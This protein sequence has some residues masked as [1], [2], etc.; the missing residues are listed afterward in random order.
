MSQIP[1]PLSH[2]QAAKF[3]GVGLSVIAR[4]SDSGELPCTNIGTGSRKHRI[5]KMEDL[6]A[7]KTRQFGAK[8]DAGTLLTIEQTAEALGI[9]KSGVQKRVQ[10]KQF[11]MHRQGRRWF[12]E[13]TSVER[14]KQERERRGAKQEINGQQMIDFLKEEPV[15]NSNG[16]EQR[17]DR[18][19]ELLQTLIEKWS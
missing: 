8:I 9:T 6:E 18:V 10:Q 19:I 11:E 12:I 1:F 3:L 5:F 4:L 7:F 2:A 16:V 17:L 14:V 15:T 13:K